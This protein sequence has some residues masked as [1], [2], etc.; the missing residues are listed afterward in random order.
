MNLPKSVC[1]GVSL[2]VR[3]AEFWR[4]GVS[5]R[6][7]LPSQEVSRE[8]TGYSR[9]PFVCCFRQQFRSLR[10]NSTGPYPMTLNRL[11]SAVEALFVSN[12]AA[13]C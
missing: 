4:K 7:R 8:K 3:P 13:V 11:F 12:S 9:Q 2:K 5:P 10:N 6:Q 1:V